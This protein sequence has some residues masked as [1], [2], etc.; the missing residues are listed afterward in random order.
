MQTELDELIALAAPRLLAEHSV[1]PQTAAKLLTLAG[2]S[3]ERLRSQAAFAALCG[4]SPVEASSGKTKR[5]RLNRGGD[6]Q[7]NNALTWVAK[8]AVR[9]LPSRKDCDRAMP[10]PSAA[11]ARTTPS[12]VLVSISPAAFRQLRSGALWSR[13]YAVGQPSSS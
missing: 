9:R 11:A 6:R 3:P 7:A 1:G 8:N 12:G 13:A 4:A 2:D 10:C 5:H